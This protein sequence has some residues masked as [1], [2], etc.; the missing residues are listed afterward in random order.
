MSDDHRN[1]AVEPVE[2]DEFGMFR[3]NAE[4]VGLPYDG[5][6]VVER[7][8][9]EV[10][11]GY[12]LSALVWGDGPPELVLLHGGA[13]NAHTWDTVALALGRPLVAIDLPGHGH[14][15]GRVDVGISPREYADDVA[16][17]VRRLAPDA[18]MVVG[19]SLGGLTALALTARAPDLVRKL[20]LVDVTPGV[21]QEKGSSIAAFVN[22]PASFPNFDEI[23]ARTV[24]FNPTRSV[25]SLRRGILHNAVQQPDGSWVWR[26]RRWR[27]LGASEDGAAVAHPDFGGLWDAVDGVGVPMM[28]VRGADSPVVDDDDVAELRRRQPNVRVEL[29]AN[30]GH[31]IQG[32]QPLELAR[33]LGDFARD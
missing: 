22:G 27:V 33:L 11:P 20:V 14:S 10:G 31:S 21:N 18:R 17:A 13:Q 2:Y 32:D 19:M 5:P 29:V 1:Q 16:V 6:P 15:D 26:Y 23:L 25:S 9:V 24:E 4:E 3:E 7:R 12:V 8:R 28:L 30:A